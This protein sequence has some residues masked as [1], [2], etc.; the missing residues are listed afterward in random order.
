VSVVFESVALSPS[1]RKWQ[2]RVQ[3]IQRLNSSLFIHAEHRACRG[4]F[5]YNP[6]ISAALDSNSGSSLTNVTFQPMPLPFSE[7]KYPVRSR[8]NQRPGLNLPQKER[9]PQAQYSTEVIPN[10]CP[11]MF[12]LQ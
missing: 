4:G 10:K 3:P 1:G 7:S 9:G 8:L 2:D 11:V 12:R 5:R 6:R